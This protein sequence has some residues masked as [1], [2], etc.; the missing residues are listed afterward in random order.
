MARRLPAARAIAERVRDGRLLVYEGRTHR[1]VLA[2]RRCPR[3]ALAFL[4][5]PG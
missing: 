1:G 4:T 2:D 3:D 5:E